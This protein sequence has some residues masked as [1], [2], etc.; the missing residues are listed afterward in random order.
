M[1][2]VMSDQASQ[3]PVTKQTLVA[4]INC[5]LAK[6]GRALQRCLPGSELHRELGD[7]YVLDVAMNAILSVNIDLEDW[8]RELGCLQSSE[9]LAEQ[10]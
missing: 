4:R 5:K 9:R 1:C 8:A 7:Y 2:A 3:T 10:D 6:E